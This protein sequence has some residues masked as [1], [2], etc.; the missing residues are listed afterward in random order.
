LLIALLP[1]PL[2]MRY[3]VLTDI[4]ANLQ[5]LE[6]VLAFASGL[7][8]DRVIVLGD[9]VG[10]GADP[11]AVVDRVRSLDVAAIVRGNHDKVVAGLEDATAFNSVA[12]RAA[13]WSL[14]ALSPENLAY[15]AALPPGPLAV[16]PDLE[17]CHGTPVDE[18]AYIASPFDVFQALNDSDRPLC[19]YGH[20]HIAAVFTLGAHGPEAIV[21]TPQHD[22]T[23]A[24]QPGFKYLINP[25]SV[26]QPRDGDARAAF[27]VL[28]RD[29]NALTLYRVSYP[30]EEAQAR[31]IEA[32]LPRAL[33]RRLAIGR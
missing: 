1:S 26:G 18:D 19:L 8:Y 24:F 15:L 21:Q 27:A 25:G 11:N 5:A 33:A 32:G 2:P 22:F 16:D 10:Y 30:I 6:A 13:R 28:D 7:E 23:V 31:I 29:R 17:I 14:A 3:L 9:L 12:E 4:H 20:T